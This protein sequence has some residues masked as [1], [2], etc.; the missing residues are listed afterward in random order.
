MEI[1]SFRGKT[2]TPLAEIMEKNE[3][4]MNNK[5]RQG[6]VPCPSVSTPKARLLP[7]DIGYNRT[8]YSKPT[9]IASW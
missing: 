6:T 4:L 9:E 2:A 3:H 1:T 7:I 8:E 5:S